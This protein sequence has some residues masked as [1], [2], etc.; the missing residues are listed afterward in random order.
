M[1]KVSDTTAYPHVTPAQADW[2]FLVQAAGGPL[3]KTALISALAGALGLNTLITG[4]VVTKHSGANT[5]DISAGTFWDPSSGQLVT[6]AGGSEVSAGTLGA[7]Q[8]N[9][10]YAYDNS[11]TPAIEVVNNA[12]PPSTTYAGNARKGGTGGNRRWIGAFLT[13]GS[14]DIFDARVTELASGAVSVF[15]LTNTSTAPFRVLNGVTANS[16][17]S[18]TSLVGC[19]PRYAVVEVFITTIFNFAGS[20][21]TSIVLSLDGVNDMAH[22]GGYSSSSSFIFSTF[23]L[24][25]ERATPGFY[26][27]MAAD[28]TGYAD[29]SG[30]RMVR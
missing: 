4:M 2:F 13:D 14:S 11:G 22:S 28:S 23:W 12:A 25:V 9:Q 5:L 3:S 19:L 20:G 21:V 10:V 29:V 26:Y 30:Y 7:N 17:G 27:Y 8:W 15:Y 18:E 24:P 1:P 6:Y 16:Y